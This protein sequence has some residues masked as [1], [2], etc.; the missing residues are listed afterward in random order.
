MNEGIVQGKATRIAEGYRPR[1]LDLFSGC[2]GL[3]LG[4]LKAGY[5]ITGA[6]EID[7]KAALSHAKNFYRDNEDLVELHGK[8]RDIT[9]LEPYEFANELKL[10][11]IKSAI[12]VI[13]GGPPCQ[14]Y[15]RVG[16]AKLRDIR[17]HPE[18]FKVDPRAD[19]YLRYL[20]YVE[21]FM[22]LAILMENVPDMLNHGG[23]NVV[24]EMVD[25]L[26]DLGYVARYSLINSVHYG[27]PQMRERVYMIAIRKE[28]ET[29]V[30]FP[31]A[32]HQ[33]RLPSGYK[34]VRQVALKLVDGLFGGDGYMETQPGHDEL[35][36][37]NTAIDAIE[38]LPR[39][40]KHQKG[41]LKRGPRRL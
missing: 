30:R 24:Q 36:L 7:E 21:E 3:S 23:R 18:A 19:L 39:I 40:T 41:K 16:R 34:G 5:Q 20:Q 26:H 32:T 28:L 27:V 1:V 13:I 37:A 25:T 10:G 31:E 38:D 4:F 29:A 14:A 6:I 12:D 2:G 8:P 9:D 33:H 15:A 22:P 11:D 17:E 35:P